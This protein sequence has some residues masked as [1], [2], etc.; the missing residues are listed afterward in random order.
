[1]DKIWKSGEAIAVLLLLLS[2]ASLLLALEFNITA[3]IASG[4]LISVLIALATFNWIKSSSSNEE[5][6]SAS[7]E[8][9]IYTEK[10]AEESNPLS[11]GQVV[12]GDEDKH[13][14]ITNDINAVSP[15]ISVPVNGEERALNS[16]SEGNISSNISQS[17][18]VL[19]KPSTTINEDSEKSKHPHEKKK[20]AKGR[21][22][23]VVKKKRNVGKAV[24]KI[25]ST[26]I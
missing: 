2:I 6:E 14:S 13:L 23:K 22:K 26:S 7:Q 12:E 25:T 21:L 8:I 4:F 17:Q 1:M 15:E 16:E 9:P 20:G 3:E 18:T 11:T 10:P 19:E 24:K 5:D